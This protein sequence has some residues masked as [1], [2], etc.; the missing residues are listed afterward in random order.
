MATYE[1]TV[2]DGSV[3]EVT[4]EDPTPSVQDTV[5]TAAKSLVTGPAEVAKHALT[6]SP[7]AQKVASASLPIAGGLLGTPVGLAAPGAAAG[8]FAR[9]AVNTVIDPSNVPQTPLGSFASTVGA[10]IVQEPKILGAIPGVP[11]ASEIASKALSKTGEGLAKAAQ[12]FSGGKA[13]D[14]IEAAKK[15]YKTYAAPSMEKAKELFAKAIPKEQNV[16][17][18][19]K[20]SVSSILEP[21]ASSARK[22]VI[23]FADRLSKGERLTANEALAGRQSMD[24]VIDATPFWQTKKRVK[25]FGIRKQFD[26]I[27]SSQSSDLKEASRMYRASILKDNLTKIFPVNKHGEYSRLAP[28][29]SSLAGTVSGVESSDTK[30]GLKTGL[31]YL[32]ATSPLSLGALATT[33][34]TAAQAFGTL[35]SRPEVRQLLLQLF[36]KMQKSKQTQ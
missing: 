25:L 12:A 16:S 18:P 9:Q 35:A 34:G 29:L 27:L 21:E 33:G 3:Y 24:D 19:V 15:G 4:T 28:M 26:E 6:M 2:E 10:G 31:G 22:V 1:V 17:V 13:K 20:E 23:D 7:E 36:E 5:K 30:K 11:K 14:Y 32:L 8:E